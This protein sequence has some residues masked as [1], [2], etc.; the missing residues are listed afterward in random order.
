MAHRGGVVH[1]RA[2]RLAK[3]TRALAV[4]GRAAESTEGGLR[5][6][7]ARRGAGRARLGAREVIEAGVVALGVVH[8]WAR[9]LVAAASAVVAAVLVAA[10]GLREAGAMEEAGGH[11]A[12]ARGNA[13][14]A[15][16]RARAPLGPLR[17]AADVLLCWLTGHG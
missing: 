3:A 1:A 10:R 6:H 11:L 4:A 2:G 13:A 16:R 12:G 15:G 17:N 5:L 14:T 9:G 8:A 7:D